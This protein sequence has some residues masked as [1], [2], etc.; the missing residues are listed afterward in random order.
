MI[1]CALP[2]SD[3]CLSGKVSE[4]HSLQIMRLSGI[5]VNQLVVDCPGEMGNMLEK[6][7]HKAEETPE[8]TS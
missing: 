1:F 4:A 8:T 5:L 3:P 2:L 7:H 6:T